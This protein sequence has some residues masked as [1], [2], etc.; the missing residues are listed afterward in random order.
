MTRPLLGDAIPLDEVKF[1]DIMRATGEISWVLSSTVGTFWGGAWQFGAIF[2]S[3]LLVAFDAL[4]GPAANV[5]ECP[6][7]WQF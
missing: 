2:R 3:V 1:W 7:D 4:R 5:D 6:K